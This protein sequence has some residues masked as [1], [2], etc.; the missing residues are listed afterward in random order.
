MKKTIA[1]N[2]KSALILSGLLLV[3][4]GVVYAQQANLFTSSEAELG[5]LSGSCATLTTDTSASQ[6]SA[7]EFRCAAQPEVVFP[8]RTGAQIA[9]IY[10]VPTSN[11]IFMAT[12]GLDTNSGTEASPV[13]TL[14]RAIA[15]IQAGGTI[16]VRAGVYRDSATPV[17]SNRIQL[18]PKSFTIQSYLNEQV[19]F[20]GTDE[21]T[22]WTS[23]GAGRWFTSWDTP[24][25]C[26]HFQTHPAG[27]YYSQVWPW[28]GTPSA[29]GPCSHADMMK[30]ANSDPDPQMVFVNN[31]ELNQ[32]RSLAGVSST[33][34]YYDVVA[35]RVYIGTD[36]S[37][38]SVEV[39]KRPMAFGVEGGAGGN[40]IRGLGFRKYATNQKH[41]G[42]YTAGAL[43]INVP[44]T[45][46]E[47]N[48]FSRNAGGTISYSN[49]TNAVIRSNAF[50]DNGYTALHAN[51]KSNVAGASA[52]N[53]IIE[54]NVFVGNNTGLFGD[55]CVESCAQ[56]GAKLAHMGGYTLKNNLFE[57]Q[58]GTAHGFW[59]DLKCTNGVMVNNVLRNNG[60]DGLFYEVSESG[61]IASNLSY[62]NGQYGF[63][64]SAANSKVF[65]NTSVNNG[66][67]GFLLYDDDRSP[68]VNGWTDVSA[69]TVGLE[70]Y[71]NVLVRN[72]VMENHLLR[73]TD[74][75]PNTGPN[76]FF[77]GYNYNSYF[78]ISSGI[79]LTIWKDPM[80]TNSVYYSLSSLITAK[81]KEQN[82][83][84]VTDG[85]DPF[86]N[87]LA[88][89]YALRSGVVP[90]GSPMPADV[91][92]AVGVTAGNTVRGAQRYWPDGQ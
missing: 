28:N 20:D 67:G 69:N 73:T 74:A 29:Q 51:G 19:W 76:A 15:L 68:G 26:H 64:I 33:S 56:A 43:L 53:M 13:K 59:C 57:N 91:A 1:L 6:G 16:V 37:G 80:S 89:N 21:V 88:G 24:T 10:P 52:D 4:G 75:S 48:V 46:L 42:S 45:V 58:K 66:Q 3:V 62:G 65:A 35:K 81:S 25:Y 17:V 85:S 78:R 50:V 84:D 5:T 27:G 77:A 54:K 61:I 71:N 83:Q 49:S 2:N 47:N 34:F 86:V 7:V 40:V 72:R 11:A 39:T 70:V 9:A 90:A 44:N 60:G 32:V 92:S 23:D 55:N 82:S 79:P 18:T 87:M 31:S 63:K 12:N 22:N 41:E 8:D 30:N 38:K 14:S 36:P